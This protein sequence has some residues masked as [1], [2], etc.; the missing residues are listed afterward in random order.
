M[1]QIPI[2]VLNI[3]VSLIFA[4]SILATSYLLADTQYRQTVTYLL[5]AI[6]WIPFS[7]FCCGRPRGCAGSPRLKKPEKT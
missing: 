5:I 3:L 6:W 2:A 1:N 4:M 7:H